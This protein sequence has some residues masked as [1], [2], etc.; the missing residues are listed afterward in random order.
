MNKKSATV[1]KRTPKKVNESDTLSVSNTGRQSATAIGRNSK[2]IVF[3]LSGGWLTILLVVAVAVFGL[4]G[5]FL[6]Q[7]AY[8]EKMTGS[9]RIAV[10]GFETIGDSE[11]SDTGNELSLSIFNKID[12]SISD[13]KKTY[14]INVWG[15]EQVG[16]VSGLSAEERLDS[17]QSIAEKIDANIVIYGLVD[18]SSSPWKIYPEFYISSL[19]AYQVEEITGQYDFGEPIQIFSTEVDSRRFEV[20][21]KF[22][23]RSQAI[24]NITIGLLYFS[25]RDYEKALDSYKAVEELEDWED[26]QGKAVLYLLM[27]NAAGKSGELDMALDYLEKSLVIDPEY[28]RPYI[29]E[30]GMYYLQALQKFEDSKDREDIDQQLLIKAIETYDQALSASHRPDKSDI[31][32]KVHFGLGQCYLMQAYGGLD[33]DPNLAANEFQQVIDEY[34]NGENPRVREM[35]AESHARLGLLYVFSGNLAKASEEYQLAADLLFD[36][37]ERQMQYQEAADEYSIVISTP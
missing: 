17:A 25:I 28:A 29:T 24:S 20:N 2:A 26:Q 7:W 32:T 3:N 12:E 31:E 6:W 19:Q 8:P 9:F 15:P 10:A 21:E 18:A 1:K 30:A 34:G 22:S 16:Y 11:S 33:V 27:G 4:G 37:P 35:A 36:N 14:D 5:Y 13:I 23:A